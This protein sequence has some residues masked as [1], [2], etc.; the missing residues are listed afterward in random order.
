M[1]IYVY[2]FDSAELEKTI[3]ALKEQFESL[4]ALIR[5]LREDYFDGDTKHFC[6]FM[7]DFISRS[8]ED[9]QNLKIKYQN[10]IKI[11]LATAQ[12]FQFQLEDSRPESLLRI[13]QKFL[14]SLESAKQMLIKLEKDHQQ[15]LEKRKK[16]KEKRQRKLTNGSEINSPSSANL[17]KSRSKRQNI[18]EMLQ[19]KKEAQDAEANKLK[20]DLISA[21]HKFQER[22]KNLG[23][24]L[25][26][27]FEEQKSMAQGVVPQTVE[28][29]PIKR[30]VSLMAKENP[31]EESASVTQSTAN[32][33][34]HSHLVPLG[35]VPQSVEGE[36]DE[37][38]EAD[39]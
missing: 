19:K 7:E 16:E 13:I 24:R 36:S 28:D 3:K 2:M 29:N 39:R 34:H 6:T 32:N 10:L 25:S 12:F 23:R 37:E 27:R 9:M 20:S 15:A 26:V 30:R 31:S 11:G 33:G 18:E 1:Y 17:F 21:A 5:T 22:Q 35:E 4:E 8:Q 14:D 38:K